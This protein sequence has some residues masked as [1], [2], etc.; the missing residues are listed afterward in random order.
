[1]TFTT[2]MF[3]VLKDADM[4]VESVTSAGL[5]PVFE[6]VRSLG[7]PTCPIVITSKG[8]EQDSGRILPEVVLDIL[9]GHYRF[10]DRDS[11]RDPV[12]P[13]RSFMAYPLLSFHRVIHWKSFNLFVILL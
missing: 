9:G 2:D 3:S 11:K 7:L 6:Q 10:H 1:M 4:I 13:K 8:I 5:R 12:L